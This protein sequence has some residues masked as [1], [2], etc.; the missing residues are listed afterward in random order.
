MIT[1]YH[2]PRCSK[3]REAL[4]IIEE[5]GHTPNIVL[6]LENPISR[7]QLATLIRDAGLEVKQAI[8]T[9]E[10]I[11][12]ELNLGAADVSDEQ[13]LDAMVKHPRLI[14]RPFVVTDKGT[15]LCR[16]GTEVE[17]IL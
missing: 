4:K 8:R 6:Y 14:N 9:N 5:K 3:S 16:P 17:A 15:R 2:N 11:Y 10:A 12:K 13:L 1:I 7:D